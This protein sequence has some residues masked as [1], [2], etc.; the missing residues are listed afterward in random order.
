MDLRSQTIPSKIKIHYSEIARAKDKKKNT[1]AAREKG[2]E[3]LTADFSIAI[4]EKN[5]GTRKEIFSVL[6]NCQ[7]K[8]LYLA[9]TSSINDS[10]TKTISGKQKQGQFIIK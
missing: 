3:R 8:P 6:N 9:K 5:K 4:M 10:E 1:K 2:I 7:Q